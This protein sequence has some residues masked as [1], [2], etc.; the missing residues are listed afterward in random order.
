[1]IRV[2]KYI[3]LSFWIAALILLAMLDP[4]Q[5]GH[6]SLCIF[7]FIGI[8]F[9]PGCGLGRSIAYFFQGELI[10]SFQSHPFG[11]PAVFIL[12]HRIYTLIRLH[13]YHPYLRPFKEPL[14]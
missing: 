1:M 14:K 13:F 4:N 6:S 7:H 8:H 9:C 3:E 5:E 2:K 12:F 10:R 11:I